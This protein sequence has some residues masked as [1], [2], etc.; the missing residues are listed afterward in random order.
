MARWLKPNSQQHHEL[1]IKASVHGPLGE[2]LGLSY[3][4]V[5]HLDYGRV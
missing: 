2:N 5:T 1:E 3:S 4:S